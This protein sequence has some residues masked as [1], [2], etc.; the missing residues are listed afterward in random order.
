[1]RTKAGAPKQWELYRGS[2]L[3]DN[4]TAGLGKFDVVYSWGVLHH[5]GKMWQA[6]RNSAQLVDRGGYLYVTLYNRTEGM[7]GSGFWARIKRFYSSS[8]AA[9][10]RASE[11]AFILNYFIRN[12]VRLRNPFPHIRDYKLNHR[13]MDWITNIRDWLGGYPYEFATVEEVFKFMKI[14]F[15]DFKLANIKTTNTVDANWFLFKRI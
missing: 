9:V 13:G 14:N 15:P 7:F 1:M 4:F 12:L 8:P 10:K 2:I 6:L 3:D 5:T 11:A